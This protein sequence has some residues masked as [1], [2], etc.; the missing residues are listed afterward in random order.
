MLRALLVTI[1]AALTWI[2]NS[3]PE[4]TPLRPDTSRAALAT[5]GQEYGDLQLWASAILVTTDTLPADGS[6]SARAMA[7][8]LAQLISPLEEDFARMTAALS[9]AQLEMVLPLWERM[10]FAHAGFAMLAEQVA[11]LGGDP[12][13]QPAEL[14]ELAEQ[15]SV[16]LD[17]AAELQRM[18]LEELT[19]TPDTPIRIS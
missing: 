8:Q 11:T 18:V 14:H 7:H 4:P 15:L 6:E 1:V 10:A 9:T 2:L 3:G 17:V 19:E 12:A 13:L 5:L 16:V